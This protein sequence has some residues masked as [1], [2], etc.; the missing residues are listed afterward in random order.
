[1]PGDLVKHG[2]ASTNFTAPNPNWTL[3]LETMQKVFEILAFYF[4]T[5][6]ILPAIGNNDCYYHD[7]APEPANA[8]QYFTELQQVFFANITAN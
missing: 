2:L 4:P 7:L 6:P 8:T 1:M 5:T 3:M